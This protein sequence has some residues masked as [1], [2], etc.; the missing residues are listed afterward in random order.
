LRHL[1]DCLPQ[2]SYPVLVKWATN[3]MARSVGPCSLSPPQQGN[4]ALIPYKD[5]A[6]RTNLLNAIASVFS[7]L[8]RY[9]KG[10]RFS[11][12]YFPSAKSIDLFGNPVYSVSC[13]G[14]CGA[15]SSLLS[16][17]AFRIP[18]LDSMGTPGYVSCAPYQERVYSAE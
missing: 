16:R 15:G 10:T 5:G 1:L 12:P 11:Y 18:Q 9:A 4:G 14:A 17:S 7:V 13:G 3:N 2:I 6:S 8:P